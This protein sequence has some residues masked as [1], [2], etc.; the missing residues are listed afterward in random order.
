[1]GAVDKFRFR[2]NP[3]RKWRK[4][5]KLYLMGEPEYSSDIAFSRNN[6]VVYTSDFWLPLL[7]CNQCG[8]TWSGDGSLY[9]SQ[10]RKQIV[11]NY[12]ESIKISG[13]TLEYPEWEKMTKVLSSLTGIEDSLIRP[14][15][16]VGPP[17]GLL[18]NEPKHQILY[19][20]P[21][22][23]WISSSLKMRLEEEGI[24]GVKYH[25]V[26]LSYGPKVRDSKDPITLWEMEIPNTL[27]RKGTVTE[28]I[29]VCGQCKRKK[30]PKHEMIID[31]DKMNGYDI[32]VIDYNSA[33]TLVTEKVKNIFQNDN[34]SNVKFTEVPVETV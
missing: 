33:Y 9:I 30:Y 19:P 8:K 32:N 5:M 23:V 14:T 27:Y 16:S 21:R 24:T 12:L 17:Q 11:M 6:P 2:Q 15:M 20:A 7:H 3:V 31:G 22:H 13:N 25:K 10:E 18:R 4:V 28:D 29:F 34:I 26:H 1:V